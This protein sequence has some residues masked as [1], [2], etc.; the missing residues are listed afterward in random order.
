MRCGT[1]A[2]YGVDLFYADFSERDKA[3][4]DLIGHLLFLLPWCALLIWAGTAYAVEAYRDEEGSPNPGGLPY[5]FLIKSA[6]PIGLTL[7][8]LQGVGQTIHAWRTYRGR[9]DEGLEHHA[10]GED[11]L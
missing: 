11:R 1:T 4:V 5:F 10:H 9:P 6:I 2:T 7:L 3:L 8:L